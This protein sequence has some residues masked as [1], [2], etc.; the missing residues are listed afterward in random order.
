MSNKGEGGIFEYSK[1]DFADEI[2]Y[3]KLSIL[4]EETCNHLT[5]SFTSFK[6]EFKPFTIRHATVNKQLS[7]ANNV[8]LRRL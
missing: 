1:K 7:T 8:S 2:F 4:H 6:M 5:F 3:H